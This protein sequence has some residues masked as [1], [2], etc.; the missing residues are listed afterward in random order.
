[1]SCVALIMW[2]LSSLSPLERVTAPEKALER[3]VS[4]TMEFEYALARTS[5]WE[6]TFTQFLSG[7]EDAFAESISEY[8]ELANFI[9][10]PLSDLYLAMLEAEAGQYEEVLEKV[11]AWQDLKAPFPL[12][13][14]FL[15]IGYLNKPSNPADIAIL[16]AHLAEEVPDNWFYSQLAIQLAKKGNDSAFEALTHQNLDL[17]ASQLL[18]V[19]RALLLSQVGVCVVGLLLMGRMFRR[20]DY[21]RAGSVTITEGV[22]PP[23][24]SAQ[25]GVAVLVRGGA[26]TALL[27]FGLSF[28]GFGNNVIELLG[29]V[30]LYVPILALAYFYLLRPHQMSVVQAFGLKCSSKS[31]IRFLSV[32]LV[33]WAAGLVGDWIISMVA[34]AGQRSIHWTEWFDQNLVW[35]TPVDV[36]LTVL[37]YAVLAPLFEEAIFRGVVYGS[38]RRKFRWEVSA[39][40]SA[41]VFSVVHGYG[42][43]GFLT[44]F[45]S[46]LLWAWAYEKTGSLWPGVVA[47]GINNLMVS[48]TL[49]AIFR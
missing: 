45:W 27:L 1:M 34:G 48:I 35:G 18:L 24:W 15:N 16:Q 17:R 8:R 39:L 33:L 13:G 30:V 2:S 3:L 46:G 43:V 31:G 7:N 12:F 41:G 40:F 29:V 49:M 10:D 5:P 19:N 21:K 28:F 32:V 26:I 14:Q 44:V 25:D 38:L 4:R 23:P 11:K 47:H 9:K 42:L 36:A 22:L 20:Q 6:Q 37:M